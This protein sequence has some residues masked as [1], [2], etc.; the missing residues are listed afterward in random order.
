[1]RKT[2]RK[3][4]FVFLGLSA[5]GL[6]SIYFP[7]PK[8]KLSPAPVISLRLE[9]RN[10]L[11]LREVL[12][13]EGG[14][15]RWV[16]LEDV[17]PHLLKATIAAEDRDFFFHSGVHLFSVVRA[18]RQNLRHGRVV[19]GASTI[20]QQVVRNIFR[21]R[22]NIFSKMREVW[23]AL[24]LERSLSKE[25]ILVQYLN[26]I[27]FGNQAYG[28]EAASRLYFD[29][30]ASHL[31]LAESALLA[32][33]PR[34]P[35]A[36]N[37][38]RNLA[39]AVERQKRILGK[40]HALRLITTEEWQRARTERL[41]LISPQ[42][43]FRAPHF[44]DYLLGR[45]NAREKR[46]WGAVRTTLDYALQARVETLL[47]NHL[48][49][50][51]HRGVTNGAA[52]I[53]DNSG[54]E[55]LCLV[56]S[57]DFFDEADGG[58][59]NGALALRQ[60]GSALKPFT[61]AL[62]LERGMTA[63]AILH[64]AP[65]QFPTPEGFYMPQNYGRRFH[66][67]VRMRDALACSYN[68]PAVSILQAVGP[69]LLY[70]RLKD[71]SFHSLDEG[72]AYYGLGLT[73][74]NGEVALLELARAYSALA[75][76]GIFREERAVLKYIGKDGSP[77]VLPEESPEHR[78][79]SPQVSYIITDILSDA[80]ARIPA[81]G[82]NSPLSLPFPAAAKTGTSKDFRDN[83]T[84]GYSVTYTVG[85]WVG[86]FNGKPM[87]NVSGI[88]GCGPLFRDIMLLLHAGG[89][90]GEFPRPSGLITVDICPESGKQAHDS[91]P[92]RV[93]EIYIEGT[94]PKE[95]CAGGHVRKSQEYLNA[96]MRPDVRAEDLAVTF[97]QDGDVFKLDPLLRREFQTIKF[98]ALVLPE[99]GISSVEWWINEAKVG[100]SSFPFTFAW[101]L[102]PG[103]YII[104]TKTDGRRRIESRPV[105]IH[106]LN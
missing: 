3:L 48:K 40:M 106:V 95:R 19:S 89:R 41:R 78:A 31:S 101:Q 104:Q 5:L 16:G 88:T 39:A 8:K 75:R 72:P 15:C 59:V 22:R 76:G 79:F 60:P 56:G 42:E 35:S 77:E 23:L 12:S 90:G 25:D 57:K 96:G 83:W 49:L 100:V 97:P 17:S 105:R 58:Q 67:P 69:D 73:L 74:G 62:A 91:C 87:H 45:M 27:P 98:R 24:R 38:Y 84:V 44:C 70:R 71:L 1:M 52:V 81:F 36:L 21:G 10:G 26:R 102:E 9:D 63:S 86:N 7:F 18:F 47:R 80:D 2:A 54:G 92:G 53:L 11:L 94:E 29:K 61:Y 46:R 43:K 66:G 64:D 65:T 20:S 6:G 55:I 32:G 13:D 4:F 51:N 30:P 28:C 14:R 82:Y 103:S 50:L 37:P 33:L 93:K 85:V 99:N 34:S 68:I